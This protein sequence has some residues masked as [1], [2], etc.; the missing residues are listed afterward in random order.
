MYDNSEKWP[1]AME[2]ELRRLHAL[3]WSAGRIAEELNLTRNSIIG[4]IGR[5]KLISN[6]RPIVVRPNSSQSPNRKSPSHAPRP[7]RSR[8]VRLAL[9]PL[10][11]ICNPVRLLDRAPHQ[12]AWPIG[13]VAGPATLMCGSN[14]HSIVIDAKP[15]R[16]SYCAAHHC[17][18][19]RPARVR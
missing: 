1:E 10:E 8:T 6:G 14:V 19:T 5:L 3:R 17:M 16:L 15:H 13:G 2:Q 7:S 18:S 4:K 9:P 12:C 11:L